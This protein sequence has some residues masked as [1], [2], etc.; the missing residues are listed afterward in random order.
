MGPPT[1]AIVK[2]RYF[3]DPENMGAPLYGDDR[4]YVSTR[5]SYQTNIRI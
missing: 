1:N 5:S 4:Q 2:I 3:A